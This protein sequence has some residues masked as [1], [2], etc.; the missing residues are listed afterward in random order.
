MDP[1]QKYQMKLNLLRYGNVTPREVEEAG[2]QASISEQQLAKEINEAHV[3]G[4]RHQYGVKLRALQSRAIRPEDVLKAG[5]EA[6]IPPEQ[7]QS[8]IQKAGKPD[9]LIGLNKYLGA[10]LTYKSFYACNGSEI[11]EGRLIDLANRIGLSVDDVAV[12][13]TSVRQYPLSFLNTAIDEIRRKYIKR[14][15]EE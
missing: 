13:I 4:K 6:S 2:Q 3:L 8:D 10:L 11:E 1:V 5:E 7:I 9:R 14:F 15:Q 12:D